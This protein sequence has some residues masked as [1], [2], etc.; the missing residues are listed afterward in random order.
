MS[1][2]MPVGALD[3]YL[4]HHV[5]VPIAP[6]WVWFNHIGMYTVWPNYEAQCGQNVSET[7]P[8]IQKKYAFSR[9]NMEQNVKALL[10][11]EKVEIKAHENNFHSQVFH[12]NQE[13]T[14]FMCNATHKLK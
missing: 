12:T 9:R 13:H 6:P 5:A 3:I 2:T 4:Q 7:P 1:Y 8:L 14:A 10:Q 11:G